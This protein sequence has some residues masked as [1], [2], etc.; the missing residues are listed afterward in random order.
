MKISRL[1]AA[2]LMFSILY[3]VVFNVVVVAQSINDNDVVESTL[4]DITFGN[5]TTLDEVNNRYD[6]ERV[7]LLNK[8]QKTFAQPLDIL[9][10]LV[11]NTKGYNGSYV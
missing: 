11:Y 7:M 9:K 4:H 2:V 10:R 6:V 3:S 8:K 1:L 5:D